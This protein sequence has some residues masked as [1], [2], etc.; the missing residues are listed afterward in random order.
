[1]AQCYIAAW[2]PAETVIIVPV[3]FA[4]ASQCF[5]DS[6]RQCGI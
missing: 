3:T 4:A 2:M 5:H 6:A 1:M